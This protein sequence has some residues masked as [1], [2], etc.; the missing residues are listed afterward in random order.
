[1]EENFL[2]IHRCTQIDT[3]ELKDKK[4]NLIHPR[5]PS[6]SVGIC[7]QI[8]SFRLPKNKFLRI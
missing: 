8:L 1:M 6:L 7:G 3:D 5:N 2:I 4:S